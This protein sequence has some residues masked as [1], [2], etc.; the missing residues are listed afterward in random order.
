MRLRRQGAEEHLEGGDGARDI[1]RAQRLGVDLAEMGE[2]DLG[3]EPQRRGAA[4]MEPGRRVARQLR[5]GGVEAE[6]GQQRHHV[7][8]GIEEAGLFGR[9]RTNG[10]RSP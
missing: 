6:L 2:H 3:A 5:L 10:V 1:E 4:G 8:L 9:R 7:G